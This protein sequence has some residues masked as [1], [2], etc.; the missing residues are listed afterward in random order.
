MRRREHAQLP[1]AI[2]IHIHE[3]V[4]ANVAVDVV[5]QVLVNVVGSFIVTENKFTL[6]PRN[7]RVGWRVVERYNP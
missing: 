1:E 3:H 5:V 4:R 7:Y 2:C 6:H